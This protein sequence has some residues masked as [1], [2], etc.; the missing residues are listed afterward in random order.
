MVLNEYDEARIKS[1]HSNGKTLKRV[2]KNETILTEKLISVQP[3]T[4]AM[5]AASHVIC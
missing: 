3:A 1:L 2:R 4:Q 5:M